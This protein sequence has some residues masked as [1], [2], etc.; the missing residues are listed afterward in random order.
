MRTLRRYSKPIKKSKVMEEQLK[1]A[2]FDLELAIQGHPLVT[3]DGRKVTN[4]NHLS[5]SA[6]P[7]P[8]RAFVEGKERTYANNG[9]WST[10]GDTSLNLLLD[11]ST[12]WEKPLAMGDEIEVLYR[13]TWCPA[14]FIKYGRNNGV[15]ALSNPNNIRSFKRGEGFTSGWFSTYRRKQEEVPAEVKAAEQLIEDATKSIKDL[16]EAIERARAVLNKK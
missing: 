15:V 12:P 9:Q 11:L 7:Y 6:L 1:T 2:P 16:T 8:N 4:F 10:N 13:E 3:R 14:I 5:T